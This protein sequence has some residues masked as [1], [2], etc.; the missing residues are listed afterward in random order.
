MGA[1]LFAQTLRNLRHA[2]VGFNTSHL[3]QFTI[4]PQFSGISREM[5]PALFDH[6]LDRLANIPGVSAVGGTDSAEL[7]GSDANS[8]VTVQGYT[9]APDESLS[10]G[11]ASVSAGY[12]SAIQAPLVAGREFTATDDV[13]H[14]LVAIVIVSFAKQYCGSA[15]AAIGRTM[16]RGAGNRLDWRQI[17]GVVRDVRHVGPRDPVKPS[18]FMPL[19]QSPKTTQLTLY[20]RTGSTTLA[21]AEAARRTM[22]EVDPSLA[23]IGLHD[24]EQQ[25]DSELS[26]ERMIGLL[27]MSFSVLATVLAGV[28]LYGVLAFSVSQRTRE[29]GI[30]MALGAE[31]SDVFRLAARSLRSQL[32]GVSAADPFSVA[33]AMLLIGV[34]ALLA[35]V[36]PARRAATVHPNTALRAE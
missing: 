1:G 20:L 34:V 31:R 3:L 15:A 24:M 12:F 22:R 25:I 6:T 2:D 26:N 16:A 4:V 7:A 29:I 19:K 9:P 28:G 32:Y 14:P 8:N 36:L 17:V 21:A 35:A 11:V 30:R 33:V 23:L 18:F 13:Q 27:A 5:T 10:V